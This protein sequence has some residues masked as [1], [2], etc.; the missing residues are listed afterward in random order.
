M[1]LVK[2]LNTNHIIIL[3]K[4]LLPIALFT[5]I[6][7]SNL[8]AN[9]LSKV[10]KEL[11]AG[12][13]LE[14]TL[15][16]TEKHTY[17]VRLSNGMAIVGEVMQN[18]IDLV[19]DIYDPKGKRLTQIDSP[20]GAKGT[21]PIDFTAMQSGKYKFVVHSLDK[22]APKGKYTIKVNRILLLKDNAKR[23]AKKELPTKTLYDLWEASLADK[24]AIEGFLKKLKG[25]HIIE[26]IKGNNKNMMV[27]YF[28]VPDKD[29]EYAMLSGGPDFL[30]LR[31]QRLGN[32][33]LFYIA[34]LVPNN[35]RFNYGFNFFKVFKAGPNNEIIQRKIAH[36]YD[37]TVTMPKAPKQKYLTLRKNAPQGK[38]LPTSL[39]SKFLAE[40]RKIT[41]HLPAKYDAKL[42]HNLLI[43]FDGENY[44]GRPNRRSRVPTPTIMDNLSADNQ[45]TPTITVLVWAM[46]KRGKDLISQKFSSFIAKELIPHMRS[47]Y[48]IGT[49]AQQIILAGSSRGG[50]AASFIAFNHSDVIG[51]VLSQSGS[52]WIKGTK[53]E[54]HWIYPTDNGKLINLYKKS[55]KLPIRFYMDVGLYDAGA[56]MLGMNRQF[57]DILETKGYQVDYHEFK[58]GHSYVNWRGTLA[59]GLISLIGKK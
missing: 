19:I 53:D 35:A 13:Q 45:I 43:V 41:V 18:G 27:T 30:G 17:T 31:F 15:S 10:D 40:N 20:N 12:M 36:V 2:T 29:T 23:I 11:Y 56:S 6:I 7:F 54:N 25:R 51:N 3:M 50:F 48:N 28:C 33:K 55:K 26:P 49:Q 32:T 8:S 47:K 39:Y 38:V 52:Y 14:Q 57:R 46:G 9:A 22:N 58:G 21:E 59:K 42:P 16:S 37:G 5:L 24:N 44:G 34:Q 4:R 1:E